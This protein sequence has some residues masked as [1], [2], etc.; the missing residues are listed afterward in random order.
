MA[1]FRTPFY[2]GAHAILRRRG[3]E[4]VRSLVREAMARYR[5]LGR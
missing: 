4:G 5:P 1:V 3:E 2:A